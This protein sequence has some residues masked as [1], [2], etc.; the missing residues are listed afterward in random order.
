M[1][2]N[3]K[4]DRLNA[5]R[6]QFN[7]ERNHHAQRAIGIEM[8]KIRLEL[9]EPPNGVLVPIYNGDVAAFAKALRDMGIEYHFEDEPREFFPENVARMLDFVILR[10]LGPEDLEALFDAALA[11]DGVGDD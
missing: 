9:A 11:L 4:L 2:K 3:Q 6:A 1:N 10:E 7:A 8:V 5:L